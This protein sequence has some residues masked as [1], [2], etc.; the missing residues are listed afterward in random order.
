MG[1]LAI[2]AYLPDR[3]LDRGTIAAAL[4]VPAGSGTRTV[5]SY[6]EDSTTLGVEAARN[7]LAAMSNGGTSTTPRRVLF[8]TASPAYLEKTNA[9]AVHAALGLDEGVAAYDVMG[10]ARSGL[11]ALRLGNEA[12]EPTL[13]VCSDVRTGLP[14][15]MDERDG[16]DGAVAVLFAPDGADD[17]ARVLGWASS[18]VEVL[19]RWRIPGEPAAHVWEERFGEHAY[20]PAAQSAFA[21]VCKLTDTDLDGIARLVVTGVHARAA[22]AVARSLGVRAEAVEDDLGATV[23]NTGAAHPGLLLAHALE[24]AAPGER[25]AVV[26][27]ADGAD[28]FVVEATDGIGRAAPRRTVADQVAAGRGDLSY[29]TFLTWR[30]M[31]EREPPRRPDPTAPAAPPSLRHEPWKF[32]FT[33]SECEECGERHLPP[34]RVCA[35]CGA[36]DR[37]RPVRMADVPARIATFTVDR[38]AFTPSPPLVAAVLDFEGGGR[39]RCE[40][41]DVDPESVA[42]GDSV[43]MTFRRVATAG[44]VHN[45]FWKGRPA[46]GTSERRGGSS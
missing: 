36:I 33:G 13:V 34:A 8:A 5:A 12:P 27:V 31:L 32:G 46:R 11:A 24:R 30:G 10:S 1:I 38:L 26:V 35:R 2:G 4:G 7:A 21:E 28:A 45:Y 23:G 9:T 39:F 43:E 19:D 41:T 29:E 20:V 6:D 17:V 15:G 16:G 44:G 14:G 42:I 40:L 37:M 3:R 18:S 22:R 25:I